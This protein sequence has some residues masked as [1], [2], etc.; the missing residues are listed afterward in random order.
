MENKMLK[1]SEAPT[2]KNNNSFKGAKKVKTTV[3]LLPEISQ[4]MKAHIYKSKA[5]GEDVTFRTEVNQAIADYLGVKIK[6]V[7][8]KED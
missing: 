8:T 1:N 5:R 4:A 2:I 6:K 7:F 3:D